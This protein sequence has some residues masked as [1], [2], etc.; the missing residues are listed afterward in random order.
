MNDFVSR[1]RNHIFHFI[2]FDSLFLT[3]SLINTQKID[4]VFDSSIIRH[5]HSLTHTQTDT[6]T[7]THMEIRCRLVLIVFPKKEGSFYI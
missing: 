7:Q 2:F 1:I 5:T 6:L 3:R 4:F